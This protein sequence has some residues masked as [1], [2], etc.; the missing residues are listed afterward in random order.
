MLCCLC[1]PPCDAS[2]VSPVEGIVEPA[3]ETALP[4]TITNEMIAQ[5]IM[6]Q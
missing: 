5:F 4:L 6:N 1:K 2:N 3:V